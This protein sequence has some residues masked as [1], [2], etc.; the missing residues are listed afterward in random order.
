MS[1]D[2]DAGEAETGITGIKP[3]WR[4]GAIFALVL[5]GAA[6]AAILFWPFEHQPEEP[7]AAAI[8]IDLAPV[9]SAPPQEE[10][11]PPGPPEEETP[12]EEEEIEE[13]EPLPEPPL[14]PIERVEVPEPPKEEPRKKEIKE[15]TAPPAVTAPKAETA[16]APVNAPTMTTAGNAMPTYLQVLH[17]H[18]ARFQ[19]YPRNARRRSQEGTVD[20]RFTIDRNGNLLT[21][22]LEKSSENALLDE[23]GLRMLER[24][25]PLPPIPDD[26][27]GES[28]D[29]T[30]PILFN[31]K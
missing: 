28:L 27:P 1:S 18:I 17:A 19:Q 7:V 31:L 12:P 10:I 24:A 20:V 21:S 23:E 16:A 25:E 13:P 2:P 26:I 4:I 22:R 6:A 30:L 9:V 29:I 5:H 15:R 11:A 14:P 8:S 3:A